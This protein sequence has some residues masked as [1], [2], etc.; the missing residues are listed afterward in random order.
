VS[1]NDPHAVRI[2]TVLLQQFTEAL[3]DT[4]STIVCYTLHYGTFTTSVRVEHG[5]TH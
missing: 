5:S 3:L 2:I 4:T 1:A